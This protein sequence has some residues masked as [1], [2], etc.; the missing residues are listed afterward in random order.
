MS[1]TKE[2]LNL[3]CVSGSYGK[4]RLQVFEWMTLT[5]TTYK[6]CVDNK[7]VVLKESNTTGNPYRFMTEEEFNNYR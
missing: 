3:D 5:A 2:N 4:Y 1:E 6:Y 7:L